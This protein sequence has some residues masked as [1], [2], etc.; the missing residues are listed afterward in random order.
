MKIIGELP[1]ELGLRPGTE[2]PVRPGRFGSIFGSSFGYG[3]GY[4]AGHGSGH[5]YGYSSGSG[6]GSKDIQY[7]DHR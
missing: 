4:G 2:S 5:G 1:I 6:S 3:Y 7:E